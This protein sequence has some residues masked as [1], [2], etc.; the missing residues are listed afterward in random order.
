MVVLLITSMESANLVLPSGLVAALPFGIEGD[1]CS[2]LSSCPSIVIAAAGEEPVGIA[3]T[4]ESSADLV[5]TF[6][7]V[8]VLAG[9]LVALDEGEEDDED[10]EAFKLTDVVLDFLLSREGRRRVAAAVLCHL[11]IEIHARCRTR[12][13]GCTFVV[14]AQRGRR[15]RREEQTGPLVDQSFHKTRGHVALYLHVRVD[16]LDYGVGGI[17]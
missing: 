13:C 17:A 7:S 16:L 12:R 2:G 15:R 14:S 4:F 10:E 1:F 8:F 5:F 9:G 3:A 6:V 11:L